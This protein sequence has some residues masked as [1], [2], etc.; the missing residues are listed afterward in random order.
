M[1]DPMSPKLFK[2]LSLLWL[3]GPFPR[4]NYHRFAANINRTKIENILRITNH[5]FTEAQN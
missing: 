2:I 4:S 5:R 1:R 3:T